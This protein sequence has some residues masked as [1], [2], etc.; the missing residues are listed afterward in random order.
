MTD[1]ALRAL[2]DAG[3]EWLEARRNVDTMEKWD[4]LAKAEAALA[5]LIAQQGAGKGGE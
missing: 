2:L 5:A 4:R 3:R 1:D